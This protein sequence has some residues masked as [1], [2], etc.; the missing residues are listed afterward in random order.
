MKK[1]GIFLLAILLLFTGSLIYANQRSLDV[2]FDLIDHVGSSEI[3][4]P[5]RAE[6][7]YG[8]SRHKI[9]FRVEQGKLQYQIDTQDPL[10]S[11]PFSYEYQD[12]DANDAEGTIQYRDGNEKAYLSED[13]NWES[14][15]D[16]CDINK[17]ELDS[18]DIVYQF[19]SWIQYTY[20]LGLKSGL[21]AHSNDRYS[22]Q[23]YDISCEGKD[24]IDQDK[25]LEKT[26]LKKDQFNGLFFETNQGLAQYARY[27]DEHHYY[28]VPSMGVD[29]SGQNHIFQINVNS[30]GIE[31]QDIAALP[32]GR[33]YEGMQIVNQ[34]LMV[35]SHDEQNFYFSKYQTD[36]SFIEETKIAYQYKETEPW[37]RMYHD[38]RYLYWNIGM[39]YRIF[40]TKTMQFV[41]HYQIED[42]VYDIIYRD[43]ILYTLGEGS[44]EKS[45][46]IKAYQNKQLIYE[47]EVLVPVEELTHTG[48]IDYGSF[49]DE[50][51][52]RD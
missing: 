9:E 46:Y 24:H 52:R 6:F 22:F 43:G 7:S 51:S 11:L 38:S 25:R 35:F 5:I 33:L 26:I 28:F 21:K 16:K 47:G 23:R 48:I 49:I 3:L 10:Y 40:D 14:I 30:H 15:Y 13:V 39:D 42:K 2:T 20:Q 17:T 18:V 27:L 1:V 12:A 50:T 4:K 34:D 41:D 45:W 32:Q 36:G 29:I 37:S 31:Y 44:T 8:I 19:Q